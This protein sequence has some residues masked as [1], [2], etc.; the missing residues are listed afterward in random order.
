[1]WT[2]LYIV[3][4]NWLEKTVQVGGFDPKDSLPGEAAGGQPAR[5]DPVANGLDVDA[6]VF[7]RLFG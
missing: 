7:G 3:R 4:I 2:S 1:M 6:E 5:A